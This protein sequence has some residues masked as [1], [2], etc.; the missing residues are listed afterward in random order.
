MFPLIYLLIPWIVL[1]AIFIIMSA[2]SIMQMMRFGLSGADT[3]LSTL[4]FAAVSATV[5]VGCAIYFL[6]IDWNA[7]LDFGA[8]IQSSIQVP[9]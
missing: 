8:L 4:I 2:L 7:P 5:I 6:A 1:V 3:Y 9:L